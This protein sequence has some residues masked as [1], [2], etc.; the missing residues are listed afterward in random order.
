MLE[1]EE[2]STEA[3]TLLAPPLAGAVESPAEGTGIPQGPLALPDTGCVCVIGFE[4]RPRVGPQCTHRER[5]GR[6]SAT[7]WLAHVT[8]QTRCVCVKLT[9]SANARLGSTK[10]LLAACWLAA[11]P[12]NPDCW[13]I[14]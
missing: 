5:L 1:K 3:V 11:G 14:V 8:V 6:V 10:P 4:I 7:H 2:A 12:P 13:L 9:C